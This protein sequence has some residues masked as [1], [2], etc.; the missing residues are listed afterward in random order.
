M[1]SLLNGG[2]PRGRL[3]RRPRL[4][5]AAI[6]PACEQRAYVVG[7]ALRPA[8]DRL[9][10]WLL[11]V[12]ADRRRRAAMEPAAGRREH[13]EQLGGALQAEL[14][15]MEPALDGGSTTV[16]VLEDG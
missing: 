2:R 13:A 4:S 7:A 10:H 3:D 14:A 16:T 9:G 11:V 8:A 15:A 1:E 6:Q 12:G 5:R